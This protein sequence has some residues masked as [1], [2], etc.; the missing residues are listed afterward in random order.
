M[1]EG[2]PGSGPQGDNRFGRRTY[3]MVAT[4]NQVLLPKALSKVF[5]KKRLLN[6]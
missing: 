6:L 2:G 1:K 5:K 4:K 3:D